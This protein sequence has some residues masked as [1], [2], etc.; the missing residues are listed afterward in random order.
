MVLLLASSS[1]GEIGAGVT[2]AESRPA[3]RGGGHVAERAARALSSPSQAKKSANITPPSGR[4]RD[5]GKT[6][7]MGSKYMCTDLKQGR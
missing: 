2:T 7:G 1:S 4:R 5:G 6:V 3:R